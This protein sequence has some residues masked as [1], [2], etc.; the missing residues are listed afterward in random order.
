MNINPVHNTLACYPSSTEPLIETLEEGKNIPP[1]EK[2]AIA[3]FFDLFSNNTMS[4][5]DQNELVKILINNKNIFDE[6]FYDSP[7]FEVVEKTA[8]S[9]RWDILQS[10]HPLLKFLDQYAHS[11]CT[12]LWEGA[13]NTPQADRKDVVRNIILLFDDNLVANPEEILAIFTVFSRISQADRADIVQYAKTFGG[14]VF[15]PALCGMSHIPL[16]ERGEVIRHAKSCCKNISLVDSNDI[17]AFLLTV[18]DVC[19]D[20]RTD[21]VQYANLFLQESKGVDYVSSHILKAMLKIPKEALAD[22]VHYAKAF[23]DNLSENYIASGYYVLSGL[24]DVLETLSKIPDQ[25]TRGKVIREIDVICRAVGFFPQNGCDIMYTLLPILSDEIAINTKR[26]L[27]E[28]VTRISPQ[29]RNEIMRHVSTLCDD[30]VVFN[31]KYKIDVFVFLTF[32]QKKERDAFVEESVLAFRRLY[33]RCDALLEVCYLL[34]AHLKTE[35]KLS[36]L[37]GVYN[38]EEYRTAIVTSIKNEFLQEDPSPFL[39]LKIVEYLERHAVF[40]HLFQEH[41]LMMQCMNI[42]AFLFMPGPKNPLAIYGKFTT[43]DQNSPAFI[44]APLSEVG[45]QSTWLRLDLL[46]TAGHAFKI[47]PDELPAD[48]TQEAWDKLIKGVQAKVLTEAKAQERLQELGTTWDLLLQECLSD[49]Y[50]S[51]LLENKKTEISIISAQFRAILHNILS[52]ESR[53]KPGEVFSEQEELLIKTAMTIRACPG[54]K[55]EGIALTYWLLDPWYRYPAKGFETGNDKKD[56]AFKFIANEVQ[57]ILNAQF[58]GTNAF[59]KELTGVEKVE[60]A[61]HQA[62]YV[63]NLIGHLVG[64]SHKTYFDLHTHVLNDKLVKMSRWEVLAIFLQH[65]T[66]RVLVREFTLAINN[67][68]NAAVSKKALN[69]LAVDLQDGFELEEDE[70]TV[71]FNEFG[72]FQILQKA[73][74]LG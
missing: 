16:I 58:S 53:V 9:E 54:G 28:L 70:I 27:L 44:E 42:K 55:N 49:L 7:L 11:I 36:Q 24:D 41:E 52:K 13:Q 45:G 17:H 29:E 71:K 35:E 38:D 72:S 2:A 73:G 18:W 10:L 31:L 64:L 39:L 74:Y 68:E 15:Y 60:Q 30:V 34:P 51:R 21:V 57:K 50:L 43:I 26:A 61:S 33:G 67:K 8:P 56:E 59:M 32:L 19:K 12:G 69:C 66:P 48:A 23:S 47:F 25:A 5:A 3:L 1:D 37:S 40:L 63:K 62:I 6:N 20:G 4:I 22:V 65:M 46:R 14:K